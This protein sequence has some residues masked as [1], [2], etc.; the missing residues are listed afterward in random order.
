MPVCGHDNEVVLD[1]GCG[2]GHDLVGFGVYSKPKQLIGMDV[3]VTSLEEA[4]SRL[5]LHEIPCDLIELNPEKLTIPLDNESIDYIHCSGVLMY[6]LDP[7]VNLSEFYRVLKTGGKSRLMV[8]NHNSI[9]VHLYVAH[10]LMTTDSKYSNL[11]IEEAFKRSTDG[12]EC[13]L[14]RKWRISEMVSLGE[15]AGFNV[16]HLGNAIS[17]IEMSI[18]PKRFEP[19]MDPSFRA[20]SREFLSQLKFDDRGVPFFKGNIAGIDG[21]YELTKV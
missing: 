7:S 6:S 21:C 1:Y 3:S 11:N 15:S 12:F 19:L 8:Y 17:L 9:W 16:R 14:S 20:E 13:P 18:L 4:G 5:K 10:I 2:P